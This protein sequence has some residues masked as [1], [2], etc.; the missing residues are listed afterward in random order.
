MLPHLKP[1]REFIFPKPPGGGPM[2]SK[3]GSASYWLQRAAQTRAKATRTRDAASKD[4]LLNMAE[5]Y[6]LLAERA[7]RLLTEASNGVRPL[8]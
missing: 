1:N 7:L 2:S 8:L 6:D 5:K 4:R 3:D